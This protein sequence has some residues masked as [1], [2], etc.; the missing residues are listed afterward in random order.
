M[1]AGRFLSGHPQESTLRRVQ[2]QK[3]EAYPKRLEQKERGLRSTCDKSM[4]GP[5]EEPCQTS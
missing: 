4:G 2:E 1:Q 3:A 5:C